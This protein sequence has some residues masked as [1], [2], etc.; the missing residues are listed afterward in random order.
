M[1]SLIV[2]SEG[3]HQVYLTFQVLAF[4][5]LQGKDRSVVLGEEVSG[6]WFLER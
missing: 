2:N 6:R 5:E 3:V 1:C 4:V